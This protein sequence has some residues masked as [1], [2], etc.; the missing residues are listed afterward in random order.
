MR[1]IHEALKPKGLGAGNE[2]TPYKPGAEL[3]VILKLMNTVAVWTREYGR[4]ARV[5]LEPEE[6]AAQYDEIEG[7][8]CECQVISASGN[9]SDFQRAKLQP[10]VGAAYIVL[11]KMRQGERVRLRL[12]MGPKTWQ[13]KYAI[14]PFVGG[15]RL[16]ERP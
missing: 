7:H 4:V 9:Y 11:P 8:K 2:Y 12:R 3:D 16:E 14:D 15:A 10:E 1:V 6:L 13:S 5:R